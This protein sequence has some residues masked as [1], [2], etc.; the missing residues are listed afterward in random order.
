MPG[1]AILTLVRSHNSMSDISKHRAVVTAH[2]KRGSWWH[3]RPR[4]V[5]QQDQFT[6]S[7]RPEQAKCLTLVL[8]DDTS[9]APSHTRLGTECLPPCC[10]PMA[11]LQEV[12]SGPGLRGWWHTG[13]GGPCYVLRLRVRRSTQLRRRRPAMPC[14]VRTQEG[15]P[16]GLV[17]RL[18]GGGR[19]NGATMEPGYTLILQAS[20][21][22][23]PHVKVRI[24]KPPRDGLRV[25]VYFGIQLRHLFQ[26]IFS[27]RRPH[28]HTC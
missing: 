24:P 20:S 27:H 2:F 11:H 19:M 10:W 25:G 7:R 13:T 1:V 17:K 23:L 6:A 4:H 16:V 21:R 5:L 8:R 15:E 12:R 3:I 22:Q 28:T 9:S 26:E 18:E 14:R